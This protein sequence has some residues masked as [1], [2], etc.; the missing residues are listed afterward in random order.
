MSLCTFFKDF[1]GDNYHEKLLA[2]VVLSYGHVSLQAPASILTTRVETPILR[3]AA[4]FYQASKVIS[5]FSPPIE[6][7][8]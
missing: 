7:K 4:K 1:T 3:S 2:T 5:L 6:R 8:A